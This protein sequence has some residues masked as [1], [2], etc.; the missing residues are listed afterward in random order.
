M[1]SPLVSLTF[2]RTN[3]A[4]LLLT[5]AFVGTISTAHAQTYPFPNVSNL[6]YGQRVATLTIGG[7]QAPANNLLLGV[8]TGFI[9]GWSTYIPPSRN[10]GYNDPVA[11]GF[12]KKLAP[13]SLR[14]PAGE[15]ANSYD[16]IADFNDTN[17]NRDES[18]FQGVRGIID[19]ASQISTGGGK[20]TDILWT[21]NVTGDDGSVTPDRIVQNAVN[22]YV[23]LK[24]EAAPVKD[25][26][27][28]NELFWGQRD[29]AQIKTNLKR[30]VSRLREKDGSLKFSIPLGWRMSGNLNNSWL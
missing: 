3:V 11:Q 16:I 9:G 23:R 18:S 30:L 26:E 4:A 28:G 15:G 13:T 27:L 19:V 7:N 2:R 10:H 1:K 17:P 22:T 5:C 12:L 29:R 25:I 6:G 20:K 24:A 14:F 8:Q 21:F